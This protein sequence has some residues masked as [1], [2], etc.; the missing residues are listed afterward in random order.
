MVIT[1]AGDTI[2]YDSLQKATLLSIAWQLPTAGGEAVYRARAILN[3][4]ID[5]SYLPY[6]K[7]Y[8]HPFQEQESITVFPNPGN[9][10]VY[11]N[12]SNEDIQV[13]DVC[14]F[15]TFG[16]KLGY[17]Q[18]KVRNGFAYFDLSYLPSGIYILKTRVGENEKAV[19]L[20]IL[21]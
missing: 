12:F 21:R 1:G 18:S 10:K 19:K 20:I 8:V 7:A 16:M 15:S 11:I 9:G 3:L 5:D 6:R 14:I 13:S 4:D 17:L 2:T